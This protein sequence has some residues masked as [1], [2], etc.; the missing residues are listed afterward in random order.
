MSMNVLQVKK[1]SQPSFFPCLP[2][3]V[4]SFVLPQFIVRPFAMAVVGLSCQWP[5]APQHLS[6]GVAAPAFTS[7]VVPIRF[8]PAVT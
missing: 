2:Q 8:F 3:S 4:F 7:L 6:T 1:A 5:L